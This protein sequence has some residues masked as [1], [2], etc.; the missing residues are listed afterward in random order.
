L[1][2]TTLNTQHRRDFVSRHNRVSTHATAQAVRDAWCVSGFCKNR[3][4]PEGVDGTGFEVAQE[5]EQVGHLGL[6]ENVSSD[7]IEVDPNPEIGI[8]R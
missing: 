7:G 4:I 6:T 3:F 8:D 1:V 2:D 5:F